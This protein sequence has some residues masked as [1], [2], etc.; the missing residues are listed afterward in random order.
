MKKML[1]IILIFVFLS[2]L[3]S[4][5][6]DPDTLEAAINKVRNMKIKEGKSD[7]E[8]AQYVSELVKRRLIIGNRDES[9]AYRETPE[10]MAKKDKFEKESNDCGGTLLNGYEHKSRAI[11]A[12][13]LQYGHCSETA[14]I[15]YHIL[16]GAKETGADLP[17]I[18][19]LN[20]KPPGYTDEPKQGDLYPHILVVMGMD[21]TADSKDPKTWGENAYVVDGW[22][23]KSFD[24]DEALNNEYIG[25]GG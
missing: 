18:N 12:W 17:D 23:G 5:G 11:W 4:F 9:K 2:P 21:K 10:G 24:L 20:T 6:A 7:R 1:F 16:K 8:I 14:C 22:Q 15:A 13:N 3:S 25:T 19:I